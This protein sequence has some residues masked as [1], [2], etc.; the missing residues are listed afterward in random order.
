MWR[1]VAPPR[2]SATIRRIACCNA[3]GAVHNREGAQ[4]GLGRAGQLAGGAL[5]LSLGHRQSL[6]GLS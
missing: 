6:A 4:A 5:V 1:V 2:R 3:V